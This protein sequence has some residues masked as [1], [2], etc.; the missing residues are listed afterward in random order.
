VNVETIVETS[1]L[2]D[3]QRLCGRGDSVF[4]WGHIPCPSLEKGATFV[5]DEA[6]YIST[7]EF[8]SRVK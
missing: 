4:P 6:K 2:G 1:L 3:G 7:P 5:E 8:S